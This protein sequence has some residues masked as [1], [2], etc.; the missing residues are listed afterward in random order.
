[1]EIGDKGHGCYEKEWNGYKSLLDYTAML[2]IVDVGKSLI[3]T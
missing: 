1:M 3:L 2:E